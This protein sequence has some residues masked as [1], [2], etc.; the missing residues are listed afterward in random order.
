MLERAPLLPP[1]LLT[2]FTFHRHIGTAPFQAATDLGGWL[3]ETTL[4][5]A[6]EFGISPREAAE[7]TVSARLM[8]ESSFEALYDSGVDYRRKRVGVFAAASGAALGPL[9]TAVKANKINE[10]TALGLAFS[11]LANRISYLLDLQGP[12]IT[13]DTACSSSITALHLACEALRNGECDQAVV[14]GCNL[15]LD[16][17]SCT[18]FQ[19]SGVLSPDGISRSFDADANG[20]VLHTHKFA[21]AAST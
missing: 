5:D 21:V 19:K 16:F 7:M 12:S 20:W 10:Y 14:V 1:A 2:T 3:A 15:T 13:I 17:H 18:T 8:V 9:E 11:V 4:F 6:R